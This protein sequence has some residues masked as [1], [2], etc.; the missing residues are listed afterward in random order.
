MNV[1]VIELGGV[2]IHAPLHRLETDTLMPAYAMGLHDQETPFTIGS[3]TPGLQFFWSSSNND[4]IRVESV[5]SEVSYIFRILFGK[6]KTRRNILWA[7][8]QV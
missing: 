5:F 6:K 3:A 7:I 8:V 1:H 2:K 4:V